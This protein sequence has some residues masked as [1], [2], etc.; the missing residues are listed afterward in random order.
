MRTIIFYKDG[1]R[2]VYEGALPCFLPED[3]TFYLMNKTGLVLTQVDILI[4]DVRK[5]VFEP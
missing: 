2:E 1:R 3:G 5:V 4:A